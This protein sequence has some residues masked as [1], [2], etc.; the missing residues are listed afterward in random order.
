M[1][2]PSHKAVLTAARFDRLGVGVYIL[3][4]GTIYATQ[5]F[6]TSG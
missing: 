5:N 2:S 4:D 3:E 1:N 6:C